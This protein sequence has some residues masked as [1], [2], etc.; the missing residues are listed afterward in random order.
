MQE[1]SSGVSMTLRYSGSLAASIMLCALGVVGC[2]ASESNDPLPAAPECETDEQ[3][4]TVDACQAIY[5]CCTRACADTRSR[6][7]P[8]INRD[9]MAA[10]SA[11]LE[12][13]YEG[14]E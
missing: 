6:T 3:L 2:T 4:E 1:Q 14:I 13:C 11:S 12:K 7:E 8:G 5:S 9:C 10:C